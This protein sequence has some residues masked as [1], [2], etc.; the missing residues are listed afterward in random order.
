[1]FFKASLTCFLGA[2][3]H[4]DLGHVRSNSRSSHLANVTASLAKDWCPSSLAFSSVMRTIPIVGL[5]FSY[6]FNV[7]LILQ[8]VTLYS[9]STDLRPLPPMLLDRRRVEFEL[10]G[11][12]PP[13]A[14]MIFLNRWSI[15]LS[16]ARGH[17]WVHIRYM[18]VDKVNSFVDLTLFQ[19][20]SGL[21]QMTDTRWIYFLAEIFN[22][23]IVSSCFRLSI[24]SKIL[25]CD[26]RHLE[27]PITKKTKRYLGIE[28]YNPNAVSRLKK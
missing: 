18:N 17:L 20:K 8:L 4:V 1:M 7:A 22:K 10:V 28:N 16:F 26:L 24:T 13:F 12:R 21:D 19:S 25:L 11:W 2:L 9:C 5:G 3:E 23:A 27:S 6:I 15:F 14:T